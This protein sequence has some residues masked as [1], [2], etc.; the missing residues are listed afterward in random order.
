MVIAATQIIMIIFNHFKIIAPN[1]IKIIITNFIS[2]VDFTK[3]LIQ[4]IEV[5]DLSNFNNFKNYS[6]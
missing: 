6:D 2:F 4:K 3:I 5:M 1:S